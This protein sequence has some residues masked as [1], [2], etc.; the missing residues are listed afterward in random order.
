MNCLQFSIELEYCLPFSNDLS[1]TFQPPFSAVF[2]DRFSAEVR[3]PAYA[4]S[5]SAQTAML[6]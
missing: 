5:Y 3:F 4:T 2:Q 1:V 6:P